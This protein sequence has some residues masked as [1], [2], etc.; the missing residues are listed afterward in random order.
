MSWSMRADSGGNPDSPG[1]ISANDFSNRAS[2]NAANLSRGDSLAY[3]E[4]S[5]DQKNLIMGPGRAGTK[6]CCQHPSPE[7]GPNT[8]RP[9]V[10]DSLM[11][12]D[13]LREKSK[14][15]CCVIQ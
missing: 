8:M 7:T 10:N 2:S 3:S 5:M 9:K 15:A 13:S 6:Q 1:R 14:A 11:S 4:D 12:D